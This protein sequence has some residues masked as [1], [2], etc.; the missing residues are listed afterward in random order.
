MLFTSSYFSLLFSGY[1][2][3]C[4]KFLVMSKNGFIRKI[5]LVS[6]FTASQLC[7]QTIAIHILTNIPRSKDNKVMKFGQLIDYNMRNILLENSCTKCGGD[8]I[9]W[10][11]SKKSKLSIC[12]D[13]YSKVL[14]SLFLQYAKLR[15]IKIYWN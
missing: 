3:F 4:P 2:S 14:Y 7:L 13:Q 6:K 9:L 5:R 10:P 12:L 1:L 11:F 8:T 15:T